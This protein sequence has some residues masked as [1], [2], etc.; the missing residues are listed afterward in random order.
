MS[1][2]V[3]RHQREVQR[4]LGRFLFRIQ[5]YERLLKA[6]V[7]E[8]RYE[9]TV[10][11]AEAF[12]DQ[13]AQKLA[14]KSLGQLIYELR[15]SYLRSAAEVAASTE[16]SMSLD[17]GHPVERPTMSFQAA[18]QMTEEDLVRTE[19]GLNHL[20]GLRNSLVHHLLEQYDVWTLEG[21]RA[22]EDH[23]DRSYEKAD[24]AYG[25][26]R[27]WAMTSM[28]A[29]HYMASFMATPQFQELLMSGRLP[30]ESID[31]RSS[32]VVELLRQAEAT[33]SADG[34]T[35]LT[36]ALELI[37]SRDPEQSPWRYECKTWRQV[38]KRTGLFE[39][40]AVRG[41][42]TVAGETWYRSRALA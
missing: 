2:E 13:R 20:L 32:E 37:R 25:T 9:G 38:L 8:A 10:D 15:K 4:K 26:L 6:L 39:M 42:A 28:E 33:A 23:L 3:A 21:C 12:R 35:S 16:A 34:W 29:R 27:Q 41:T 17:E 11:T 31:W 30:D 14:T 7:A 19:T 5:Q 1:D 22:A 18:M 40:R 24:A 36:T